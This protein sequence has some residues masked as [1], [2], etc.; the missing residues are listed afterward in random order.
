MFGR[1]SGRCVPNKFIMA[2][3]KLMMAARTLSQ[4]QAGRGRIA[5][6]VRPA[7]VHVRATCAAQDVASKKKNV[8]SALRTTHWQNANRMYAHRMCCG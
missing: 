5:R 1:F 8:K 4:Q 3:V 7:G 2:V 6:N